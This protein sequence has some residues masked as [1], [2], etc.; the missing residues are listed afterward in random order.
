VSVFCLHALF[1]RIFGNIP[2]ILFGPPGK[3]L[4]WVGGVHFVCFVSCAKVLLINKF[5]SNK[6]G[7]M[8]K[9]I[10]TLCVF[11]LLHK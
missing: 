2:L 10:F 1:C 3:F 8:Q 6:F 4:G 5:F 9:S 11:A 7:R